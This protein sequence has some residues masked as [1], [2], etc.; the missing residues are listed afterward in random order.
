[1][2]QDGARK[3]AVV[4][5]IGYTQREAD[6]QG[7][8]YYKTINELVN[9]PGW[10]LTDDGYVIYCYKVVL[11]ISKKESMYDLYRF[12]SDIGC[13]NFA[14][15]NYLP[16]FQPKVSFAVFKAG[17]YRP[18]GTK[19]DYIDKFSTRRLRLFAKAYAS[20]IISGRK[21]N[22]ELLGMIVAPS[23]HNYR[24]K[25]KKVIKYWKVERM[26][27][28]EFKKELATS[29][30]TMKNAIDKMEE[31]YATAK[32]KGDAQSMIRVA[33]NYIDIFK[34]AGKN[35]DGGMPSL[36]GPGVLDALN[37]AERQLEGLPPIT[38]DDTLKAALIQYEEVTQDDLVAQ[39]NE[40][41]VKPK[42]GK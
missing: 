7:V 39:A 15:K 4:H 1:V 5:C 22:W 24:L 17:G 40:L 9:G 19:N 38:T 20:F 32:K 37:A 11:R 30:I 13:I 8:K 36:E 16:K 3:K 18:I 23:D 25:A 27:D 2:Q 35:D 41:L 42:L 34:K 33:E 21:V 26:I 6:S 28:E 31:A 10:F 29:G 14:I 12:Q